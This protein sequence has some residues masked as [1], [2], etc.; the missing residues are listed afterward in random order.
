MFSSQ[1][2]LSGNAGFFNDGLQ[3][4]NMV[5]GNACTYAK[6]PVGTEHHSRRQI[7]AAPQPQCPLL[8]SIFLES[9]YCFWLQ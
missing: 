3:K 2:L 4:S 9:L 8:A 1:D 7:Q 6:A 5:S